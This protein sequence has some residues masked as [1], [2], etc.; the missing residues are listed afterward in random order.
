[1]SRYL[2]GGRYLVVGSDQSHV[3]FAL[4]RPREEEFFGPYS[5][6]TCAF[7]LELSELCGGGHIYGT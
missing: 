7:T 1:V 4:S 2:E 5:F 3:D 6:W